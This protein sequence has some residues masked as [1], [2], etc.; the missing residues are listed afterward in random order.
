MFVRQC[1]HNRLLAVPAGLYSVN[2]YLKFAM[3]LYFKPTTAK[4][5][6]NLK[7]HYSSL[8]AHGSHWQWLYASS[9]QM[10]VSQ[11]PSMQLYQYLDQA[12]H[13]TVC[14]CC[15][16][17]CAAEPCCAVLLSHAVLC[18]VVLLSHAVLCC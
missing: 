2:N 7:V 8:A 9:G 10:H 17:P 5:L 11:W 4:M 6:S 13:S 16:V 15:A 12:L 1:H 3:Q 14:A 18:L